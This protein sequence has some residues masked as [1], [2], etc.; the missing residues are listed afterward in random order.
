MDSIFSCLCLYTQ[1]AG[2]YAISRQNN[3]MLPY[4]YVD[5][6]ILHWYARGAD[7]RSVGRA[8]GRTVTWLPNA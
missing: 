5:W 4:L 7:G 2:G 8:G 6:V 3:F 1:E